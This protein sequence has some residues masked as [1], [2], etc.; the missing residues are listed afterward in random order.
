M[1]CI[2]Y[3]YAEVDFHLNTLASLFIN[4]TCSSVC[5][6]Q[7]AVHVGQSCPHTTGVLPSKGNRDNLYIDNILSVS[8]I[9]GAA[10]DGHCCK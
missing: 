6:Q 10:E 8:P 1:L 4:T 7:T 2:C 9:K 5:L 3:A